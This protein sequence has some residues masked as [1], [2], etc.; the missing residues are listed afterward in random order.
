MLAN[1]P[2]HGALNRAL[3]ESWL[4]E[5]VPRSIAAGRGLQPIWSQASEKVVTFDESFG[6]ARTRFIGLL[7][8]LGLNYAKEL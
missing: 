5:W 3:M 2:A 1:D 6:R 4:G 7:E 8:E